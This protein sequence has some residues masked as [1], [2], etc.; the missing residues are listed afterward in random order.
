MAVPD[1]VSDR[2]MAK[3]VAPQTGERIPVVGCGAG[4]GCDGHVVVLHDLLGLSDWQPPFAPPVVN[5]GE[6]VQQAAKR[7]ADQC[8]EGKYLADGGVYGMKD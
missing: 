2:I 8:A 7:W 6:Q 4:P 1:E 3:A 5:L